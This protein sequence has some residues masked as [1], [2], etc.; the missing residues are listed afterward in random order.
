MLV[1]RIVMRKMPIV[2]PIKVAGVT[3]TND[4]KAACMGK[5]IWSGRTVEPSTEHNME[6]VP[7]APAYPTPMPAR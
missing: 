7:I 5:P 3:A 6:T 4:H 1:P 2:V